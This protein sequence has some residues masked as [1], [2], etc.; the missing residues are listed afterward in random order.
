VAEGSWTLGATVGFVAATA[1]GEGEGDAEGA[2]PKTS[3]GAPPKPP[4]PST[5]SPPQKTRLAAT[6]ATTRALRRRVRTV[7]S[8]GGVTGKETPVALIDIGGPGL[9]AN[10]AA[11]MGVMGIE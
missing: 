11:A 7:I 9:G 10:I 3:P 2:L 1:D 5:K 6:I 4:K 8:A